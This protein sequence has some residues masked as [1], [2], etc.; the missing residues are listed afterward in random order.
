MVSKLEIAVGQY[1]DKGGRSVNRDF[2]GMLAPKEPLLASKGI[3]FV[4]ADGM[5]D[6]DDSREASEFSVKGFLSDYYSTPETWSVKTSGEKVLGTI[7]SWLYNTGQVNSNKKRGLVTTL[8]ILIIKSNTAHI[9]H[10]G[11]TRIYRLRDGKLE[12]LTRD[13]RI[14]VSKNNNYL[15]RAVGI[16][17]DIRVDYRSVPLQAGDL[18][19]LTTDGVHDYLQDKNI[20]EILIHNSS[21][22][23][24][25]AK[26]IVS[27][28]LA[29]KSPDNLTCQ[30]VKV[31]SLPAQDVDDVYKKISDLPFPPEL[32][33]EMVIDGYKVVRE[34]HASPTSQLYIAVDEDTGQE[35]VI[36]TPSVNFEDDLPYLQRFLLEEWAGKRINDRHVLKVSEQKRKR[37]FLYYI[38]EYSEGKTLRQWINENPNPDISEVRRIVEQ[39]ISGLRA[40]HRM[41]MLHQDIKPENVLIEKSGDV[42]II[43]FGSVKIGGIDEIYSPLEKANLLGT[44]NYTAP[45]LIIGNPGTA[46]SDYFALGVLV[47]EMLTGKLPYGESITREM[48]PVSVSKLKYISIIHYN[49]MIPV[50][51]DRAIEKMVNVNPQLRYEALSGFS[52]D[53]SN[54]NPEFMKDVNLPLLERDPVVFWRRLSIMLI[55]MNLLLIYFL[56]AY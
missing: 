45:E 30:V 11:D 43:D 1:S 34:L 56:A 9:F 33:E 12:L 39:I 17:H 51:I 52:Y 47:Y 42:K 14:V 35:V 23:D 50:W 4:I 13:H 2:Y 26:N 40:F 44:K 8:S 7:N 37:S 49:P 3:V 5:G 48:T 32:S 18:F 41:E 6:S 46:K 10:I 53:L 27:A 22:L 36:K 21:S 55:I 19:L 54:P 29:N 25:P 28:A 15:N 24:I 16:D 31:V 20:A 38:T